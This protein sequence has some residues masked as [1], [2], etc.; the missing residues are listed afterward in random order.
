[1]PALTT[2][3]LKMKYKNV[4]YGILLTKEQLDFL[5]DD[6]QGFHRMK[7]LDT[8]LSLAAIEPFHYEKKNFSA[9]LSIG[10]FAISKVELA[11][12]WHCDRKTAQKIIDLFNEVGILT[13][14]ANNRTTIHTI[15]CLA[16][17]FVDGRDAP[18][19]NPNYH[20]D[21]ATLKLAD[22]G[23]ANPTDSNDNGNI[24]P[25]SFTS[26]T[27]VSSVADANND[28]REENKPS[29]CGEDGQLSDDYLKQLD[30]HYANMLPETDEPYRTSNDVALGCTPSMPNNSEGI[31]DDEGSTN[32]LVSPIPSTIAAD[33]TDSAESPLYDG[34]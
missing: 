13:S 24:H 8:F 26:S 34:D 20:R 7:A 1:M 10:Q 29:P 19:K 11:E 2:N 33:A 5:K 3:K 18:I 12:L 32:Q 9:D 17:W 4:K 14:I 25:L 28:E 23:N 6:N 16:F 30:E 15:H 27:P 21:T 22:Q 31:S